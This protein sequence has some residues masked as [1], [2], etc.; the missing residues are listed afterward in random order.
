MEHDPVQYPRIEL[1][2][3]DYELKF[4]SGDVVK[5]FREHQID[6][7]E[8]SESRGAAALDRMQKIFQAGVAHQVSLTLEEIGNLIP[9]ERTLEVQ[10]VISQALSKVMAEAIILKPRADELTKQ[11][12]TMSAPLKT[13]QIQ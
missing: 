3:V 4:R 13:E 2:G 8:R 1:G 11:I 12:E 6:L 10:L 9:L 7:M 5:L